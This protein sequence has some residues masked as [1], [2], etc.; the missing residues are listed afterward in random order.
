MQAGYLI[1][2]IGVNFQM[3]I[4]DMFQNHTWP[5]IIDSISAREP[6]FLMKSCDNHQN[7]ILN[8]FVED[9]PVKRIYLTYLWN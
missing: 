6:P 4:L 5:T 9:L 1:V 8:E 7:K 3:R 2:F